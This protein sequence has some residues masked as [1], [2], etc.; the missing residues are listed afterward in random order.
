MNKKLLPV[1][2]LTNLVGSILAPVQS[3][4]MNTVD[5]VQKVKPTVVIIELQDTINGGEAEMMG[6]GFFVGSN[7]I[8]TNDHMIRGTFNKMKITSLDGVTIYDV[9][10]I[11]YD[12]PKND[13]AIL[14]TRQVSSAF[15]SV[16]STN[17]LEG[18]NVTVIGNPYGATGTVS[19]GI[20]SAI[21]TDVMQFTAP[22]THGSSGSPIVNDDGDVIGIVS[23]GLG[24][25]NLSFAVNV[26]TIRFALGLAANGVQNLGGALTFATVPKDKKAVVAAFAA[27][28]MVDASNS[29]NLNMYLY[30]KLAI[31]FDKEHVTSAFVQKELAQVFDAHTSKPWIKVTDVTVT[32]MKGY[33]ETYIV[34]V[35]YHFSFVYK[36]SRKVNARD[37]TIRFIVQQGTDAQQKTCLGISSIGTLPNNNNST[38]AAE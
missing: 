9:D 35:S 24:E 33:F 34:D 18:S 6:T 3:S 15:L 16:S 31:Y 28:F 36:K 10:H 4:A 13:V 7:L 27:H 11:S 30:P 5:I 38:A 23:S 8:A 1:L 17:P 14:A 25:A 26:Q 19:T 12:D 2:A 20:V 29:S 37:T 21:R 22:V 32:P